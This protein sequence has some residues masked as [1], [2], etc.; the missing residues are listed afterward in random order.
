[1]GLPFTFHRV[2]L[3]LWRQTSA[4]MFFY[5]LIILFF[6]LFIEAVSKN[7]EK[8]SW[9]DTVTF[10]FLKTS[11]FYLWSSF[12]GWYGSIVRYRTKAKTKEWEIYLNERMGNI[13]YLLTK[14]ERLQMLCNGI[15]VCPVCIS[16]TETRHLLLHLLQPWQTRFY[17]AAFQI[18]LVQCV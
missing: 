8:K 6:V 15:F 10:V 5:V 17:N 14:D 4:K 9:L 11:C 3:S 13:S 1:M 7:V 12:L 2:N 18:F 16:G